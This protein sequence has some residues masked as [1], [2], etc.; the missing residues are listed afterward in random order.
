MTRL[1]CTMAIIPCLCTDYMTPAIKTLL[2]AESSE[3]RNNPEMQKLR[4]WHGIFPTILLMNLHQATCQLFLSRFEICWLR[5][6]IVARPKNHGGAGKSE[7]ISSPQALCCFNIFR[8]V[9][10]FGH[11]TL[12]SEN[13]LLGYQKNG[14]KQTRN[15]CVCRGWYLSWAAFYKPMANVMEPGTHSLSQDIQSWKGFTRTAESNHWH[16]TTLKDPTTC[17]SALYECF[18]ISARPGPMTISWEPVQCI[19]TLFGKNPF[20]ISNL[21][22]SWHNFDHSLQSCS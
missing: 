8:F 11:V 13:K 22:L 7:W 14:L 1:P 12:C 20:P 9:C 15:T 5:I 18:L 4:E 19:V 21:N 17:L 2:T 16:R 3:N 6:W 10:V